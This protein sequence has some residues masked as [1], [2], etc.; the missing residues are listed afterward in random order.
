MIKPLRFVF[1]LCIVAFTGSV[2]AQSQR[3][4]GNLM[5]DRE[6]YYFR[7]S[8]NDPSEI[9]TINRICSVDGTDGRT[10][11]CYANQQQYEKL[12]QAGYQP[13][14][15]TPPSML[16]EAVMWE[17]G[18]RA[19]YD[20]N[21][22]LT[23]E[24]YVSMMEGFPSSTVSGR[25]CTLLDLGTLS[26]SNHRR[27]LGVRLNN[28]QPNGKP[29]F[30]YTST[31]HGDEVTGM[32]L[33]L[34]LIDE[35]CTSTDSR[36]VNILNNVDLFIF[37]CTN[38]DGTYYGGNSTVSGARRYNG[39]GIDLNR[40][41]PDFDDGAH[42]DGASYYQDEAQWMMDLAQEYLFTM[43]ANYHGGA[44]VMNY[45][46]DTY[47]PLHTDDAWW[48]YVSLEY[49]S[50]ARQV[51]SSYMTDT[52]SN[53]ITN[54]YAWYTITG[55]RQDYMN[56]Y[57]QCREITIE[58]SSTKTPSASQLPNFWNYNH[59]SMLAYIEQC[60]NGIHGVVYDA[61]T[62]QTI[63]G[64]TITVLD[65]DALGSSVTSHAVGDF[66]RPI[67]GGNWTIKVTKDGYCS[68][69]MDVNVSDGQR[70]DL[71]IYLYPT[72]S[73]PVV[74]E[75]Y[76]Q[77]I[78]SAA[79]TFVLGYLNGSN[80]VMPT[81]NNG[82]ANTTSV[83]VNPTDNGFSVEEE[84]L[85]GLYT[86]TAYTYGNGQY[87]ISYNNRYL[88]RSTNSG[89]LTWS[90][91]TS[92][93]GRWYIND[94]G[95]YVTRNNTNYYLNYANGSFTTGTTN[96]GNVHFYVAGDCP[97]TVT[98]TIAVTVNPS[99]GGSVTG[100]GEY[101]EDETCTLTATAN[102]GYTFVGWLERASVVSTEA[103][104]SFQVTRNRSLEALFEADAP[105]TVTQT[106]VFN[107][108]WNWWTPAVDLDGA[109]LLSLLENGMGS[110][111]V[112]IMSQDG[113]TATNST[114]GWS[115]L[116]GGLEAGKMYMIKV[117]ANCSFTLEGSAIDPSE[118]SVTLYHGTNWIG[119]VGSGPM[120]VNNALVN[121]DATV[122][123]M[124][125]A[126][127][128]SSATY[129]IYGWG[130]VLTN[131]TPGQAYIYNSVSTGN[132]TFVFPSAK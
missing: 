129:S 123:D 10:V 76:E 68:Q 75:C 116:L 121:L 125:I 94:N 19:T 53:G 122:G 80:L 95:I 110:N 103:T 97:S 130:G 36:I 64:A 33:M 65:H 118:H 6:E 28:G 104:Y 11:V 54:G 46:W 61:N 58:C 32:I 73:C 45:P 48:Q 57:G 60:L 62:N 30:L 38:P 105:A 77:T 20:W 71:D 44:E 2:W 14:L 3:E 47:Q 59:N 15:M 82:T 9:Q 112:M 39:N 16:E 31:M 109:A 128:G 43:G 87:Y 7:L 101:I 83:D 41:F 56:Y 92:S 52:E 86:L 50:L 12:L 13:T 1:L 108:G 79:G 78:P 40:H 114:Y 102:E 99:E 63:E 74:T 5:R 70:V 81:H 29:K 115:G 24:Q 22:Y 27:I 89:S 93:S 67:K 88:T 55:S 37:P 90:T 117:N 21:S 18:D 34:R 8:V 100:D 72:G 35:F 113:T 66:H 23:Y 85:P 98:Y 119:F 84:T 17:G 91:S 132:K 49:V 126:Q 4:L 120:S 127:D 106:V 124:I 25:T 26:T 107:T 111:G 69:T 96:Q 51:N 42:P 131:L